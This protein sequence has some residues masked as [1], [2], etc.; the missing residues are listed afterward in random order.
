[1]N[2]RAVAGFAAA[3]AAMV[4]AIYFAVQLGTAAISDRLDDFS[5]RL[6][7]IDSKLGAVEA[8]L[9]NLDVRLGNLEA[10]LGTVEKQQAALAE[11]VT[12]YAQMRLPI[13]PDA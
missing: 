4:G 13:V 5:T 12:T 3:L 6:G 8:R 2:A 10:K 9:G 1:M 7:G 11:K